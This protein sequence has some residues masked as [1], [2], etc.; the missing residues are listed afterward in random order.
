MPGILSNLLPR[1]K[2]FFGGGSQNYESVRISPARVRVQHTA[3]GDLTQEQTPADQR[4]LLRVMRAMEKNSPFIAALINAHQTYAVGDGFRY[5]PLTKNPAWNSAA[6]E[7][8]E[9]F[10]ARPEIT[11]RYTWN[12]LLRMSARAILVDGELFF[13]RTRHKDGAPCLQ[14]VE[15][16]KV[17]QPDI[18]NQRG[19]V[20]GIKF[21]RQ[22]RPTTYAVQQDDGSFAYYGAASIIHLYDPERTTG[23]R[24]ISRIQVAL[25]CL[26]DKREIMEAERLAVKEFSR[27]TFVLKSRSGEFDPSDADFF[28]SGGKA[29]KAQVTNPEDVSRAFGGLSMA[30]GADEELQ[31]FETTRPNLNVLAMSEALE[32]EIANATGIS[33][34]FLLNPTKIGG[35]V[36]RMELAKVERQFSAMG[37]LLI[38]GLERKATQYVLADRITA[39]V[40]P[41]QEGWEKMA[42]NQP[43]R[44]SIDVGRESL[45]TVRELEAG[46]RNLQDIIEEGGD[47]AEAQIIARLDFKAWCKQVAEERGLTYEDISMPTVLSQP[48]PA[49]PAAPSPLP[50]FAGQESDPEPSPAD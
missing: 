29:R 38:D 15:A 9:I 25:N 3:P 33:S 1:I 43:R 41:A 49:D 17:V 6:K 37:R 42:F 47:D 7:Q 23:A 11:G 18:T 4:E 39:G 30:I 32:R 36:V 46:I 22:G 19:W 50:P 40:L 26:R 45:A 28:G 44:L 24:G 16:H 5:Q 27:R 12:Q 8:V 31:A 34:D 14:V 10:H 2:G 20:N 13:I 48:Q 35:P 21:D